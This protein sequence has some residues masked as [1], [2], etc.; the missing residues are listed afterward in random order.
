LKNNFKEA[1]KF[2]LLT[3]YDTGFSGSEISMPTKVVNATVSVTDFV[4]SVPIISEDLS[5]NR[6]FADPYNCDLKKMG[7]VSK[8][9]SEQGILY[10]AENGGVSCDY[11]DYPD[12]KYN[13]AYV[14]RIAGEN[15]SGRSLKIYLFN[16][17]SQFAELEEV[18]P[19]GD[20]DKNYIIYPKEKLTGSGY[21]LSL[22]TRSFGRIKS[23]NLLSKVDFYQINIPTIDKYGGINNGL[24]IRDYKKY[25]TFGY[26]F[27]IQ[28]GGLI[29]LSQGYEDGWVAFE[30]SDY[31]IQVL[32]HS[33]ING[34]ANGWTVPE[35]EVTVYIFYWPQTLEWIGIFLGA[36]TFV[37]FLTR[38]DI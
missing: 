23:E 5:I 15:K 4:L 38:R 34:W 33:K 14:L 10:K 12:L 32:K 20:F 2:G 8:I 1:A 3:I 7:S 25:S 11:L 24:E 27:D 18:L 31:K 6:G 30:T 26:K 35:K 22:E 37:W 17:S 19:E 9:N 13:Q 28:G 36:I 29:M 16:D 21:T